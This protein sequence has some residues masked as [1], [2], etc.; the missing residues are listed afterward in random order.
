[1]R[2]A[3]TLASGRFPVDAVVPSFTDGPVDR[4]GTLLTA[5]AALGFL[6]ALFVGFSVAV[7]AV[8]I[9]GLVALVTLPRSAGVALLGLGLLCTVEV[10]MR[11]LLFD[12]P[13]LRYNTFNYIL[14]A[15]A[16]Y[17]APDLLRMRDGQSRY[18]A[19]FV[20]VLLLQLLPSTN[21]Y[22]G[23]VTAL[24]VSTAFALL[25]C[26]M[27]AVRNERALEWFAIVNGTASAACMLAYF[28]ATGAGE[29][30]NANSIGQVPIAG[31]GSIALAASVPGVV[32]R[33]GAIGLLAAANLVLVFPTSSRGSMTVAAILA[34]YVLWRSPHTWV[35]LYAV[36]LVGAL[37]V[38]SSGVFSDQFTGATDKWYRL[39]NPDM[40]V[41]QATN[42]RSDLAQFGWTMFVANPLGTG[43]GSFTDYS[44]GLLDIRE[45]S[46]AHSGWIKVLAENGIPG[47]MLL[48][49]YILSFMRRPPDGAF[50]G[51][52][53]LGVLVFAV[54][55]VA[56]IF[57]EFQS[58]SLW[59]LSTGA[60]ALLFHSVALG[61]GESRASSSGLPPLRAT[62]GPPSPL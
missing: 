17:M 59:L 30:L 42:R 26:F 19:A 48:A 49:I 1:M 9:A 45:N 47:T 28:V 21:R 25:G 38:W 11:V 57:T 33:W 37:V 40:D 12:A 34:V 31:L 60:S 29:S 10:P 61:G 7:A 24:E 53:A 6:S 58:R 22:L 18:L 15:L 54:L 32:R 14:A 2:D 35:R 8:A 56:L 51:A 39:V 20:V 36:A 44:V 27:R 16:L 43:T 23:L 5:A 41:S 46:A 62:V 3:S 50:D 4:A 13:F 52:R 55:S